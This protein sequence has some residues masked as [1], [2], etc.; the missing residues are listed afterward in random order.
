M[1]S[2]SH[3]RFLHFNCS[4]PSPGTENEEMG[5][6]AILA[7]RGQHSAAR[8]AKTGPV[9]AATAA[10]SLFLLQSVMSQND[11]LSSKTKGNEKLTASTS[12]EKEE[13]KQSLVSFSQKKGVFLI[14]IIPRIIANSSTFCLTVAYDS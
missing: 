1:L 9:E 7:C 2:V 13:F 8:R 6:V 11:T 3:V 5:V 14:L 10:H 12:L 4:S